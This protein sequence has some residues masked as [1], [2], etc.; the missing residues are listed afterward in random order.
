[1]LPSEVLVCVQI[2]L[3]PSEHP[4]PWETYP[5]LC[6]QNHCRESEEEDMAMQQMGPDQKSMPGPE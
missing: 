3:L 2:L 5:R 4:G 6:R 1:M